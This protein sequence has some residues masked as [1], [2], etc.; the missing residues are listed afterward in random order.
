MAYACS[1]DDERN[2]AHTTG[3]GFNP[4]PESYPRRNLLYLEKVL[5]K[6]GYQAPDEENQYVDGTHEFYKL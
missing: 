3:A 4:N 2:F 1:G 6:L 5:E